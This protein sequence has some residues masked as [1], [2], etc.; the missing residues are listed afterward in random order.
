M[1]GWGT[2]TLIQVIGN[3]IVVR[4]FFAVRAA[5]SVNSKTRRCIGAEIQVISYT[6]LVGINLVNATSLGIDS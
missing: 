6:I 1:A 2:W 3:T 5:I 4:V